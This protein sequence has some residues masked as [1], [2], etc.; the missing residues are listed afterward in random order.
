[1]VVTVGVACVMWTGFLTE[2]ARHTRYGSSDNANALLAGREMVR[3]NPLLRGWVL[4]PDSYW[5]LDLPILGLAS[6]VFG[7]REILLHAV[8]AA[9]TVGT[10]VTGTWVA[11]MDRPDR[12]RWVAAGVLA[13]VIGLPHRYLSFFILQ[14]PHHLATTLF[15]LGAFGLLAKARLGS[16]RWA[17]A[18]ALLAMAVFSDAI[19]V[20]IGVGPVVGA[21]VVDAL[22]RRRV[23]ALAT[24]VSAAAAAMAGSF[25]LRGL[26]AV[27]GGFA[28]EPTLDYF[29]L[30][31][32]NLRAAPGVLESLVGAGTKAGLS[33]FPAAVHALVGGLIVFAAVVTLARLGIDVVRSRPETGGV[34]GRPA[35]WTTGDAGGGVPSRFR[36]WRERP[37][38]A[39][40]DGVLLL[41]AL[42]GIV[43]FALLTPPAAARASARYLLPALVFGAVLAARRAQEVALRLAAWPVVAAG[44]ALGAVYMTA[45]LQAV[46]APEPANPS[47]GVVRW[48]RS[49]RLD[50]GYGQYWVAG[51]TTVTSGGAVVVRPVQP[52]DQGLQPHVGFASTRWFDAGTDRHPFLFLILQPADD[53]GVDE[54]R[55]ATTFGPPESEQ[56]IGPYRVLVWNHDLR[57]MLPRAVNPWSSG[58]G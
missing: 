15:C 30:W 56:T 13:L 7:M 9:L 6:V 2:V 4:P 46:R 3:G 20:A 34:A 12:R 50:R 23:S 42:A 52:A 49:Q 41:G 24:P 43:T 31:R 17:A 44:L 18:V 25:A 11:G 1:M 35:G 8:P 10:V 29:P 28:L 38:A 51:I 57:P 55:A 21:G 27:A 54:T 45:P 32:N 47:E 40:G 48:L 14:G 19:A 53:G 39:W 26:V 16:A 22:R 58:R 36:G 33:P 5:L 37:G